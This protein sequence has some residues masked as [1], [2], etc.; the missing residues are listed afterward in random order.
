MLTH[1]QKNNLRADGW[2]CLPALLKV[3]FYN[4]AAMRF[5][6]ANGDM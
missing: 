1:K 4:M 2:I 5:I 3:R 6:S